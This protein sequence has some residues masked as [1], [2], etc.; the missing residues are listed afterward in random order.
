MTETARPPYGYIRRKIMAKKKEQALVLSQEQ[1][2][3][4][5][6]SMSTLR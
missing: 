4:G 2:A 6:F 3:E 1:L 5:I